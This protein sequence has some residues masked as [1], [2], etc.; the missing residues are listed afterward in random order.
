MIK[1]T[2][3][4]FLRTTTAAAAATLLTRA[5]GAATTVPA[6]TRVG[7]YYFPQWHVDPHNEKAFHN[8]WTE[9]ESVRAA[10]PKFPGHRQPKVPLWGYEDESHPKVMAKKIDA[11]ADHAIDFFIF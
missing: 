5:A 6:S 10:K 11:A 2:R 1:P 9:W 4:T 7:V 8:G 3:R